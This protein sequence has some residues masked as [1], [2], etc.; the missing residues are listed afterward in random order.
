MLS[1]GLELRREVKAGVT[2]LGAIDVQMEFEH[3]EPERQIL[4]E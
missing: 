1:R 3:P 2:D 4:A